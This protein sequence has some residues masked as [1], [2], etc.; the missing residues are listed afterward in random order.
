MEPRKDVGD[1]SADDGEEDV[2]VGRAGDEEEE[3]EDDEEERKEG[4]ASHMEGTLYLSLTCLVF[5][6]H[7]HDEMSG[8]QPERAVRSPSRSDVRILTTSVILWI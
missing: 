8:W 5:R 7:L 2:D 1:A 4:M 6:D 3:G